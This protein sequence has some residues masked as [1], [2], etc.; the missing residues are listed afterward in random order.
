MDRD[1]ILEVDVVGVMYE[2]TSFLTEAMGVCSKYGLVTVGIETSLSCMIVNWG[3]MSGF[4][5]MGDLTGAKLVTAGVESALLM[6]TVA[7]LFEVSLLLS[8]F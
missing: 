2:S 4:A 7:L 6:A 3:V 5:P 8:P 1:C